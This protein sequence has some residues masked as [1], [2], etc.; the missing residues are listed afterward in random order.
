MMAYH[1]LEASK[2]ILVRVFSY[3]KGKLEKSS[4]KGGQFA[5]PRNNLAN[6]PEVTTVLYSVLQTIFFH[7]IDLAVLNSAHFLENEM[8]IFLGIDI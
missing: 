8:N 7:G 2:Q 4:A 6:M 3:E 1:L 5:G